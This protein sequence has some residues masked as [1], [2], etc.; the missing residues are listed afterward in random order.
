MINTPHDQFWK[1]ENLRHN[2]EGQDGFLD[3][4]P[5]HKVF[6][7]AEKMNWEVLE[8]GTGHDRVRDLPLLVYEQVLLRVIHTV[9]SQVHVNGLCRIHNECRNNTN[10][11]DSNDIKN[12]VWKLVQFVGSVESGLQT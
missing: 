4:E 8:V 12:G 2:V 10:L 5:N 1:M 3:T 11:F 6:R 9:Y 7:V